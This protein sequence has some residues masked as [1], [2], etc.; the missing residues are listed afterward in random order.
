MAWAGHVRPRHDDFLVT[1]PHAMTIFGGRDQKIV[2]AWGGRSSVSPSLD[3]CLSLSRTLGRRAKIVMAWGGR[4]HKIVMARS[5]CDR[6]RG[7]HAGHA[8]AEA[9]CPR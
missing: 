6:S 8:D 3:L 5:R 4:D 2:M 1:S 9:N 7:G